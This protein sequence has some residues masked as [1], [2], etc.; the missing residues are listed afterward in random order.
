MHLDI[1]AVSVQNREKILLF[2]QFTF[3]Y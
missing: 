3:G 1:N 2:W